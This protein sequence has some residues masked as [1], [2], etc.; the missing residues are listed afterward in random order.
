MFGSFQIAY[1]STEVAVVQA[2]R[3]H[4]FFEHLCVRPGQ[5]IPVARRRPLGRRRG[6]RQQH[7]PFQ[8]L[9]FEDDLVVLAPAI[10]AGFLA[11]NFGR[12]EL[13]GRGRDFVPMEL[14]P[15]RF[16]PER[17]AA[18]RASSAAWTADRAGAEPRRRRARCGW[19]KAGERQPQT[20]RRSRR[21]AT[22]ACEFVRALR[23]GIESMEAKTRPPGGCCGRAR[24]LSG[25]RSAKR[26]Q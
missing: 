15:Q 18:G 20:A 2:D 3:R 21:S 5:V 9:G 4:E 1:M 22:G 25:R 12:L 24:F 14:D 11:L 23:A 13:F 7:R 26:R 8:A 19:R 16:D 10:A 17:P 6:H